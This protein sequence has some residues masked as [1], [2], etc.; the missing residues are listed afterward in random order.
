MMQKSLI[1]TY[2]WDFEVSH[3]GTAV[4]I[5]LISGALSLV[6]VV[7]IGI[8]KG[9][10]VRVRGRL[11]R[12]KFLQQVVPPLLGGLIIGSI[13]YALPLTVGRYVRF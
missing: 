5:G 10:F 11:E 1:M 4:I 13:N 3:C 9:I 7:F 12:N 6:S 2:T 8:C